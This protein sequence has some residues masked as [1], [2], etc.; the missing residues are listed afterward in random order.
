[1]VDIKRGI[2][3]IAGVS[4]ALKYRRANPHSSE[5]EIMKHMMNFMRTPEFKNGKMEAIVGVSHSLKMLDREPQLSDRQ[6]IDRV[7]KE[8]TTIMPEKN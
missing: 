5:E 1:M 4:E 2:A 6:I 8:I 3:M 7:M